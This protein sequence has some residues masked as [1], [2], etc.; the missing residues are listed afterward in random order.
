MIE[1]IHLILLFVVRLISNL[2]CRIYLHIASRYF[3]TLTSH[4]ML[5]HSFY[6]SIK[7]LEANLHGNSIVSRIMPCKHL[8]TGQLCC[9][10]AGPHTLSII[11]DNTYHATW[12]TLYA[13]SMY[14]DLFL[15][16]EQFCYSFVLCIFF[17]IA[18]VK[19]QFYYIFHLAAML[20]VGN[21]N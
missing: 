14:F 20:S 12:R 11:L 7:A 9:L 18:A 19:A 17:T 13:P 2:C 6:N 16:T 8:P 21:Y 5:H 10:C 15:L 3:D 4:C 1:W